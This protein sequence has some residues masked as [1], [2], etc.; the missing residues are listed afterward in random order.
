MLGC[1]V[2][3]ELGCEFRGVSRSSSQI[4]GGGVNYQGPGEEAE[5]R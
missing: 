1:K 5:D 3:K 2:G 4:R